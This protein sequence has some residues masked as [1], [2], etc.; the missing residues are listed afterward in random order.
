LN[1]E[2]KSSPQKKNKLR[3]AKP[4]KKKSKVSQVKKK[5][6]NSSLLIGS[7]HDKKDKLAKS[8]IGFAS[9]NLKIQ[10]DED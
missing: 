8:E 6:E 7:Y 10:K 2:E 9:N 5:E 4:I 1:L 3:G